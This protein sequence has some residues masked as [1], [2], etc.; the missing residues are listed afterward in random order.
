M[1]SIVMI[2]NR[3]Q[4]LVL[5]MQNREEGEEDSPPGEMQVGFGTLTVSALSDR[6]LV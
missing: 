4:H 2:R 3:G 5:I 6:D 1:Q